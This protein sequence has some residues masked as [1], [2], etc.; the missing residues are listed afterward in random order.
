MPSDLLSPVAAGTAAEKATSGEAWLRALLDAEAALA[1][2]QARLGMVPEGVAEAI[3]T[4]NVDLDDL[5][6]RAR[7]A[8]N[9]VVPLVADLRESAGEHV[10]R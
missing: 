10:H 7:G 6:V 5:A 3:L 8:G 2:A 4:A 1:R 9:P